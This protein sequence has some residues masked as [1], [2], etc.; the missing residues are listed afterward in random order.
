MEVTRG[1][2]VAIALAQ[3]RVGKRIGRADEGTMRIID[4]ALARLLALA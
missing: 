3:A 2:L 4:G 1:D